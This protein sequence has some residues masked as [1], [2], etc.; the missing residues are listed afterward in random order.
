MSGFASLGGGNDTY[1][2]TNNDDTIHGNG[3]NDTIYALDGNDSISG[4]TGD[5]RIFAGSGQDLVYAG[6]DNDTVYGQASHDMLFGEAGND[7]LDGGNGRD[8]LSGGSGADTVIGGGQDDYIIGGAGNDRLIGDGLSLQSGNPPGDGSFQNEGQSDD[9][10]YFESGFG[11]DVV[12]D[13]SIGADLLLIKAGTYG[14]VQINSLADLAGQVVNVNGTAVI[15]LGDDS[16]TLEGITASQLI[17][18]LNTAV[19]LA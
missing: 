2:G 15:Q 3:G 13:F 10:F 18:Q 8:T 14:N 7:V 5:D 6:A 12:V 16:I 1:L 9:I 19:G 17:N 11:H 4:G